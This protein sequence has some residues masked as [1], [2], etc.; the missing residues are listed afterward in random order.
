M[1]TRISRGI[2]GLAIHPTAFT[3]DSRCD[4]REHP[5]SG[6]RD[7]QP[8]KNRAW[9]I[10]VALSVFGATTLQSQVATGAAT[11]GGYTV[12]GTV[13]DAQ[14]NPIAD[15]EIGIVERDT[16]RRFTRTDEKGKFRLEPLAAPEVTFRVRR[17]GFRAKTV[18]V[19]ME[20]PTRTA[21][22]FVQLEAS[23]ATLGT[24]VVD[25]ESEK[26]VPDS[27]LIGF[28]DRAQN[29]RFGHYLTPEMLER[30]RPQHASDALRTVAGVVTRPSRRIGSIVRL[31]GCG[32]RGESAERV[33]P[34][35]WLDGVRLAGAEI[36]EVVQGS[37]IAAIE[38]YNSMAGI[39][40]QYR[41]RS[42]V[43]GTILVWTK[44]R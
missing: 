13:V 22:V 12:T 34:L 4:S 28:R 30:M 24:V 23:V 35:V 19:K 31:R 38:V 33:G 29:N 16:L 21:N 41:D 43:C 6:A 2:E 44:S 20:A 25:D 9:W 37:D 36:D 1:V 39:P 27:R 14:G 32:V 26:E 7:E 10:A 40:A 15:A 18:S 42:A 11:A 5:H 8:M 17:L 3:V